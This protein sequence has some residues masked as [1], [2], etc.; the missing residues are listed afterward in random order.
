MA[1]QRKNILAANLRHVVPLRIY[2]CL[3]EVLATTCR[4]IAVVRMAIV[5]FCFRSWSGTDQHLLFYV[6]VK[7]SSR[8]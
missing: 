3:Q 6:S 1:T 8:I 7:Y 2:S 5:G 4:N